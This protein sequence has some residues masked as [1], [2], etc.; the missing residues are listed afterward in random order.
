MTLLSLFNRII[1][2]E[3]LN[4]LSVIKINNNSRTQRLSLQ[5]GF[6]HVLKYYYI[7]DDIH[8]YLSVDDAIDFGHVEIIDWLWP[9]E[10]LVNRYKFENSTFDLGSNYCKRAAR[11][12]YL[13]VLRWLRSRGFDWGDVCEEAAK[14]R[15]LDVIKWARENGCPW[16]KQMYAYALIGGNQEVINWCEENGC[17]IDKE[18]YLE[19][20]KYMVWMG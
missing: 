10:K 8:I 19:H 14:H 3:K 9:I 15:H 7:K 13:E 20:Y 18:D 2:D 12:G 16:S 4:I 11:Y 1:A 17:S 5:E 6:V